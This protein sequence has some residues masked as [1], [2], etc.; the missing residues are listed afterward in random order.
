MKKEYNILLLFLFLLIGVEAAKANVETFDFTKMGFTDWQEIKEVKGTN[1]NI[2]FNTTNVNAIPH[3]K[4]SGSSI[5]ISESGM[6]PFT[7]S[8]NNSSYLIW[9][10][11]I[12]FHDDNH[13]YYIRE[14]KSTVEVGGNGSYKSK[15]NVTTWDGASNSV[16]FTNTYSF[17]WWIEK[18]EVFYSVGGG[19]E[20]TNPYTVGD[21]N[22][23][24]FID[25]LPSGE[26]YIKGVVSQVGTLDSSTGTVSYHLSDNGIDTATIAVN[27]GKYLNDANITDKYQIACGDTMIVYGKVTKDGD[28]LILQSPSLKNMKECEDQTV[29]KSAGWATYVS[30]RPID[31]SKTASVQAFQT[32]YDAKSNSISLTPVTIIPENTAVVLKGAPGNYTFTNVTNAEQLTGNELT[33]N[34]VDTPVTEDYTIYVFAKKQ[35]VCGF[36]PFAK[37]K[38]VPAYKGYLLIKNTTSAKPYYKINMT[39][40]TNIRSIG[41]LLYKGL[42]YNLSGERVDNNYKGI[43]IENGKKI[44]VK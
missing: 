32:K 13:M 44:I 3:W 9:R 35:G 34:T 17:V 19:K 5:E 39:T 25:K 22:V 28:A 2:A 12:T 26:R 16:T 18:I 40:P 24:S 15:R 1:I 23:F 21:I 33:F 31:F 36:F 27:G 37:G 7:I 42:R 10:I 38:S 11:V 8:A 20:A 30:H 43:V 29:V 6:N 14:K 41:R 4:S